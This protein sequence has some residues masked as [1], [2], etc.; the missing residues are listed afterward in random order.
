MKKYCIYIFLVCVTFSSNTIELSS[1]TKNI[2]KEALKVSDPVTI[3]ALYT[4]IIKGNTPQFASLTTNAQHY[5][6]QLGSAY[7]HPTSIAITI[8]NNAT[9][10]DL[11]MFDYLTESV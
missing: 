5:F 3:D 9:I 8:D 4:S 2:L 1:A 6:E 10:R 7:V 11:A